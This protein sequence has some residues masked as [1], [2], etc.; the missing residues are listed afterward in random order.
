MQESLL[1]APLLP[2]LSA[3]DA[4]MRVR[5]FTKVLHV[6]AKAVSPLQRKKRYR[7]GFPIWNERLQQLCKA[8]RQHTTDGSVPAAQ[9]V[10]VDS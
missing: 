1:A 10:I 9:E 2:P 6:A 7:K 3:L 5:S 4:D 8:V